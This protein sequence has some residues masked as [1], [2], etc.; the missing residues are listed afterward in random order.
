MFLFYTNLLLFV[1]KQLQKSFT[2]FSSSFRKSYL[3][4]NKWI[5]WFSSPSVAPPSDL[6][7]LRLWVFYGR[8]KFSMVYC[9]LSA[10][11]APEGNN[12]HLTLASNLAH[13][14]DWGIFSLRLFSILALAISTV[15]YLLVSVVAVLAM[16]IEELAKSNGQLHGWL[17]GRVEPRS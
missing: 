10:L 4:F 12:S 15:L 3:W 16:P 13:G 8:L 5:R 17:L 14:M 9:V 7:C 2:F 6:R 11:T 1:L